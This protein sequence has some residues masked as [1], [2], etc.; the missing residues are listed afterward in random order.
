MNAFLLMIPLFLIRFVLLGMIYKPAL[1]RAAFFAPLKDGERI[2]YIFYQVSNVI[3]ILYPLFLKVHTKLPLLLIG[4]LLYILGI[5][6]LIVST[7][8]FA[9]P[10]Q[11][12]LNTNG[13]YKI[14]RNPM[15][16]GYFLYYL[17]CAAFT[18]SV[19]LLVALA[20]FQISA[21]WII[22]S[23]ERWCIEKFGSDYT[24][25]MKRVRRYL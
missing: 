25:Y 6:V 8:A 11:N 16:V 3:I 7:V 22:L 5:I 21:H 14:S 17:G 18:R 23:E 19:L 1:S 9:K 13:V 10:N 24:S 15:Y 20:V 4:L 2:A 12:G